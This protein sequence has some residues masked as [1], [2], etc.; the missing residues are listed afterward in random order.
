MAIYCIY[1]GNDLL[2][3]IETSGPDTIIATNNS[4]HQTQNV[5]ELLA[6]VV[7]KNFNPDKM[8]EKID[9]SQFYIKDEVFRNEIQSRYEEIVSIIDARR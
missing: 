1:S 3:F 6:F 7:S 2:D 8:Q 5:D 9:L 4:Y